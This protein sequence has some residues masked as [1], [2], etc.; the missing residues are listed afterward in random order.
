VTA[1][2]VG[3]LQPVLTLVGTLVAASIAG[4]IVGP[5]LAGAVD[6][7]GDDGEELHGLDAAG[8]LGGGYG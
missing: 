7:L 3:L 1:L 5:M 6:P 2:P 8:D 4:K